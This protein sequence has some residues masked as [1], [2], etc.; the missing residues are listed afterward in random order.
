MATGEDN[1]VSQQADPVDASEQAEQ[2]TA[3]AGFMARMMSTKAAVAASIQAKAAT[4]QATGQSVIHAAQEKISTI[5]K[6]R[7]E[8]AEGMVEGAAAEGTAPEAPTGGSGGGAPVPAAAGASTGSQLAS[9]LYTA[10]TDLG[11]RTRESGSAAYQA[12]VEGLAAG[13]QGLRTRLAPRRRVGVVVR[14]EAKARPCPQA[15]LVCCTVV[16]T[17]GLGTYGIFKSGPPAAKVDALAAHLEGALGLVP[18][19]VDPSAA[20]AVIK[21]FLSGLE[22]PLLVREM[23]D[24]WVAAGSDLDLVPGLLSDLPLANLC[25]LH[26]LME[27]CY[28]VASQ[29]NLTGMNALALAT[30]LCGCLLWRQ[31]EKP[32]AAASRVASVMPSIS[33]SI[34]SLRARLARGRGGA[35]AQV[36]VQDAALSAAATEPV[37]ADADAAAAGAGAEAH[38]PTS[39]LL[40]PAAKGED[41]EEEVE[42]EAEEEEADAAAPAGPRVPLSGAEKEAVV[43]VVEYVILNFEEL[44]SMS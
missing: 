25:T 35:E 22:E 20:A 36:Q 18:S 40:P 37:A 11:K 10:A 5:Q 43:R 41:E 6:R 39:S 2:A 4:I 44:F 28:R 13:V 12:A 38:L 29:F 21:H 19:D 26:V 24:A 33:A 42:A 15:V 7:P 16:V 14:S 9:S 1:V 17:K 3:P 30:E 31:A 32:G 34:Q 23:A 27:T 8:T